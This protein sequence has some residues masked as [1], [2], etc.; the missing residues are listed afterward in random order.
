MVLTEHG[1]C[2]KKATT[3]DPTTS[4][5]K[6]NLG[7]GTYVTNFSSTIGSLDPGA[8]R[9]RA[10]AE[11]LYG[12]T[13]YQV[14][15]ETMAFSLA[16]GD[17]LLAVSTDTGILVYGR[18]ATASGSAISGDTISESGLLIRVASQGIPTT[19]LYSAKIHQLIGWQRGILIHV[20]GIDG[21]HELLC[22]GLCHD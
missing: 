8:Y 20:H 1:F 2:Y 19:A 6:V 11:Y 4:D 21:K 3:G 12:G 9:I 10:Y 18:T 15:G 16:E 7:I 17:Q 14:Y 22:K 5:T 13:Y